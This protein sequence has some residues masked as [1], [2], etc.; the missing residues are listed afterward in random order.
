MAPPMACA[1]FSYALK[2][3]YG[4]EEPKP[5]MEPITIR[6]L[7]SWIFSQGNPRR[8]STPGPKFSITM[9]H[10]FSR[11]T[12]TALPSADFMLTVIE[13]LLQ[14]NI[15]KYRLSALGTSRSWPRVASPAGDSNLITSAPIHASSCELV[16]PACTCVMS[17]MRTPFNASIYRSPSANFE[18]VLLNR[19]R[20]STASIS[21]G[22]IRKLV[23]P[24]RERASGRLTKPC[25]ADVSKIPRI[26]ITGICRCLATRRPSASS[27]TNKTSGRA[28]SAKLIAALSP[29]PSVSRTESLRGD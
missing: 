19:S 11:S 28:V 6:G 21:S 8:S 17:R 2:S 14:F 3:A 1:T 9:S 29:I 20:S 22:V 27:I 10:F 25:A 12:K 13:R 7:I 18:L 15:V 5:L 4:P 24:K 16:G 23:R 26:P